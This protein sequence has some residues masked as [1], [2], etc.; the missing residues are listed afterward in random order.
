MIKIK[1]RWSIGRRFGRL[2]VIELV[3]VPGRAKVSVSCDRG[4]QKTV[5]ADKLTRGLVRSCGCLRRSVCSA[6]GQRYWRNGAVALARLAVANITHG[7]RREH[8][9]T[10]AYVSWEAMK[11]RCR[12][13]NSTQWANYGGRGIRVCERWNLFENFLADMGQRPAGTSIDRIDNNGGYEP[14][15]CR[16]TSRTVQANNTRRSRSA[17][18]AEGVVPA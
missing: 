1:H 11:R 8:S 18:L 14:G 4:T 12:N 17:E 2:T 6:L 3:A 9:R 7:G 16:W 10:P 15:N 13:S 5:S